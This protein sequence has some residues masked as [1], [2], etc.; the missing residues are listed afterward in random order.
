MGRH[1]DDTFHMMPFATLLSY[2]ECKVY[3][4]G[5]QVVLVDEAYTSRTCD[6]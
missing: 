6:R 2:I 1:V 3:P 4:D 5:T